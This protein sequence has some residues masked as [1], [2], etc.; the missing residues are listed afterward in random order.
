MNLWG[1]LVESVGE[2]SPI[3]IYLL[4]A[5]QRSA[6]ALCKK[7]EELQNQWKTWALAHQRP[8]REV[9]KIISPNSP[10]K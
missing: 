7:L 1:A 10:N 5:T 9:S 4:L 2:P 8:I 3:R 6:L